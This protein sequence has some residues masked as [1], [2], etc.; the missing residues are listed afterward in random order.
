[1]LL[2]EIQNE[3]LLYFVRKQAPR[4]LSKLGMQIRY[5][6]G[7][8]QDILCAR[9]VLSLIARFS[10]PKP[11]SVCPNSWKTCSIASEFAS[12]FTKIWTRQAKFRRA[13]VASFC[14]HWLLEG[15]M[16]SGCGLADSALVAESSGRSVFLNHKQLAEANRR[17]D[18]RSL[19]FFG[20]PA[21]MDLSD[22]NTL[23]TMGAIADGWTFFTKAWLARNLVRTVSPSRSIAW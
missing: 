10:R 20:A 18:L 21:G 15:A 13:W 23:D 4:R 2:R 11:G 16:E 3:I 14:S 17:E 7:R 5:R 6:L 8:P 22:P 1:M 9:K 19:T 12:A